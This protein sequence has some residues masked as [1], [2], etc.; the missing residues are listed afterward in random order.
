MSFSALSET[1]D[2]LVMVPSLLMV[3]PAC[4]NL[5]FCD[6]A[7]LPK[8]KLQRP[9]SNDDLTAR[10]PVARAIT[11]KRARQTLASCELRRTE[12]TNPSCFEGTVFA[13]RAAFTTP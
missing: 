4:C 3:L 1:P 11:S 8:L 9:Q 6:E 7:P 2:P 12:W 10:A 5:L 13:A